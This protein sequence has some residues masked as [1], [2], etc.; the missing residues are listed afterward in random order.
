ML[1]NDHLGSDPRRGTGP[2]TLTNN[3]ILKHTSLYYLS[4]TFIT[5]SYI[6]EQNP[7]ILSSAYPYRKAKTSSPLLFTDFPYNIQYWPKQ[8]VAS[9][10]NLVYYNCK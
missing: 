9:V 8:V 1:A 5:A 7:T 3:E 2:S 4:K 10:G 6:Y